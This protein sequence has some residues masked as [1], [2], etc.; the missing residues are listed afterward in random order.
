M[1]LEDESGASP[2]VWESIVSI[3]QPAEIEEVRRSIGAKLV[4]EHEMLRS[5]VIALRDILGDFSERARTHVQIATA[6]LPDSK[7]RVLLENHIF[8]LLA[9]LKTTR[10]GNASMER[11]ES[12]VSRKIGG[13]SRPDSRSSR[14]TSGSRPSTARSSTSALSSSSAP[15]VLQHV[16]RQ[17]NA[18]E[19]DK[20][21]EVIRD[22]LRCENQEMEEEIARL[23][24]ALELE[25]EEFEEEKTRSEANPPSISELR[26][27]SA[28][29]ERQLYQEETIASQRRAIE[30]AQSPP[31]RR[32]SAVDKFRKQV[33]ENR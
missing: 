33:Y 5:E 32:L 16:Q 26:E 21:T 12:Y 30:S 9:S 27:C 1:D 6:K 31:S 25:H 29:L 4:D 14:R 8:L 22:A 15:E 11:V 20:V 3:V 17:L 28:V 10:V 7:S 2:S 18:Y 13:V 24:E 23:Q 19:I